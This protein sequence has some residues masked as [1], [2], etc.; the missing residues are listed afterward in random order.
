MSILEVN[1]VEVLKLIMYIYLKLP[2]IIILNSEILEGFTPN[3]VQNKNMHLKN[4][5][6]CFL[7]PDS[8]ASEKRK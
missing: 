5:R 4:M 6:P 3:K 7:V 8:I 1:S 2:E